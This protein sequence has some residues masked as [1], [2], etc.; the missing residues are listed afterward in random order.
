MTHPLDDLQNASAFSMLPAVSFAAVRTRLLRDP[1]ILW[2][3]GNSFTEEKA[4]ANAYCMRQL[5]DTGDLFADEERIQFADRYGGYGIGHASGSGRCAAFDDVQIKGVG[6][7]PLST[8]ELDG[9][10]T[11][12]TMSLHEAARE[13]IWSELLGSVLPYGTV[14]TL[15]VVLVGSQFTEPDPDG[16][17]VRR[18]RS[19]LM[20]MFALRPAHFLRA[21]QQCT[22]STGL[23]GLND[24]ALRA[25]N[26]IQQLGRAFEF[27]FGREVASASKTEMISL[28]L[29][30]S[31]RRFAAQIASSFA[32]RIFHGA[33]SCSNLALDGR[34][35]DFGVTSYVH[36]YRRY[37]WAKGWTDQWQ[38]F[39]PIY[40]TLALLHFHVRKYLSGDDNK[41]LISESELIEEFQAEYELR[42]ECE[43]LAM[44]GVSA[45]GISDF[46]LVD[47][48]QLWSCIRKIYE[49]GADEVYTNWPASPDT[50]GPNSAPM[51]RGRFDLNVILALAGSAKNE[52]ELERV[53]TSGDALSDV[54][55]RC[56]FIRTYG[57]FRA[58]YRNRFDSSM[59]K[60]A[61]AYVSMQATRM[62]TDLGFLQRGMLYQDLMSFELAPDGVSKFITDTVERGKYYLQSDH[63]ELAGL[64]AIEQIKS[65]A[66]SGRC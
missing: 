44:C 29:R 20:R 19:L 65:L 57:C 12:G 13:T 39:R 4:S 15:A 61:D 56:E 23:P 22:I 8:N 30:A 10:H 41:Q 17:P 60:S 35:L 55:L 5:Q 51:R 42:L 11:S 59:R 49:R 33:L 43:M 48:R 7:T 1:Q 34:F 53:L 3:N 9:F 21:F 36:G 14:P 54:N 27:S 64:G 31:A 47:R 50:A 37:A 66:S 45:E 18:S 26:A 63:P 38:Q 46:A 6:R 52:P 28:G 25:R 62:N 58:H 40:R 24:D 32:R 2:V 16:V